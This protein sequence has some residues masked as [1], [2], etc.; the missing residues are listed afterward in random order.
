MIPL[1]VFDGKPPEEKNKELLKRKIKKNIYIN[2][3]ENDLQSIKRKYT[4]NKNKIDDFK[5]ILNLLGL[6][7]VESNGEADDECVAIYK[8]LNDTVLKNIMILE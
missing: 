8:K 4:L 5:K 6:T 3:A 7:Y 2:N 1:F